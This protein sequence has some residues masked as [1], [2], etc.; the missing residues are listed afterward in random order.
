MISKLKNRFG[1]FCTGIKV[2]YDK[3]FDN[4]PLKSLRFCEAVNDSFHTPVLFN[5]QNLSCLGSKRSFG[6][7]EN[8]DELI[9]HISQD[10]QVVPET[11][12]NVLNDIPI[13]DSKINNILLGINEEMEKDITPD[14]Y[15]MYIKPKDV[16]VLMREYTQKL[17]KLPSIKPYFF[18][19]VCGNIFVRTYKFGVMSISFGCPES[20]KYGGVKDNLVIVG[21][22]YNNCLQLLS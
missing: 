19:S 22:P 10:S 1:L 14:L 6:V 5:P 18:L 20:R 16:L 3:E 15:I 13:I 12:K 17:N 21:I 7:F 8:D 4:S 11:V 9:Q 2:N